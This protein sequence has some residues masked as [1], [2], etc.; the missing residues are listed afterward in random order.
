MSPKYLQASFGQANPFVS[1]CFLRPRGLCALDMGLVL[2]VIQQAIRF[3]LQSGTGDNR[4]A[5]SVASGGAND[6]WLV[7]ATVSPS[8]Y[9]A[10]TK[11]ATAL[12]PIAR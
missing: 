11:L 4:P 10:S 9:T 6:P 7:S 2:R 12:S 5:I 3:E 1:S 8:L